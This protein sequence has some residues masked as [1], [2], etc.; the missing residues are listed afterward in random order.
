[1]VV[2]GSGRTKISSHAKHDFKAYAA[3]EGVVALTVVYIYNTTIKTATTTSAT[4]N[5]IR[6]Y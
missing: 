3:G 4:L 6:A 5:L 1:M 2:M